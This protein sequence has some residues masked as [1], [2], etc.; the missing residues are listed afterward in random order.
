MLRPSSQI[1]SKDISTST[2]QLAHVQ[3]IILLNIER[4]RISTKNIHYWC[5]VKSKEKQTPSNEMKT[6]MINRHSLLTNTAD[7]AMLICIS[8]GLDLEDLKMH[9][10]SETEV[11]L[12]GTRSIMHT[13][14]AMRY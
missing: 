3:I 6:Q 5:I 4:K 9:L 10:I 12:R 13:I 11:F 1:M 7:I 8:F 2:K 14:R